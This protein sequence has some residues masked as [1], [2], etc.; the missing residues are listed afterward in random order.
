MGLAY[1]KDPETF[2]RVDRIIL[3]GGAV[4]GQGNTTPVAEFNFFADPHAANVIVGATKGYDPNE[5]MDHRRKELEDGN[6]I[7]L[8][9]I[10][11]PI[12]GNYFIIVAGK[13]KTSLYVQSD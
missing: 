2:S 6:A 11:I 13:N 3:L 4:Y 10:M 9:V 8:H 7:P 1:K 5:S 12:E